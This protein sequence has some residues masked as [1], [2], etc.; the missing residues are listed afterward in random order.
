M[1]V[2]EQE[3]VAIESKAG[4]TAPYMSFKGFTTLIEKCAAEGI[5]GLFDRS[6]FGNQSGSLTAQIRGTLR[7]FDLITEAYVPTDDFKTLVDSDED[8]RKEYLKVMA[9]TRYADALALGSNATS[10]QLAEVFRQRGI[11]GATID[12]AIGFYLGLTDYVGVETSPHF[13]KRRVM[14][15]TTRKR[16][17]KVA[18]PIVETPHLATL[19]PKVITAD[20]QKVK[21]VEMLMDLATK[22]GDESNQQALLDLIE[23][24]LGIGAD[25]ATTAGG[26]D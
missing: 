25:A 19:A 21:Y 7:Y 23:K 2:E 22:N 8:D 24:A 17:P 12:K 18:T 10:G 20:Q 5:P 4:S 13:K 26:G 1:T 6:Y 9:E 16:K 14:S 11:S 3:V 15:S